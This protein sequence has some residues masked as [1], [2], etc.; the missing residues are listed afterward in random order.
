MT[1]LADLEQ[2]DKLR[3]IHMLGSGWHINA[4]KNMQHVSTI[5]DASDIPMMLKLQRAD[6]YIEQAEMFIFQAKKA[7]VFEEVVTFQQPSIRKLGWHI[8]IG[9]KSKFQFLMPKINKTLE[10]LQ[11]SGE[12]E[13]IKQQ[14]F[15]K[16]GIE[17]PA[18]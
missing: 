16:Y 9:H 8:F 5:T 15:S 18:S 4:L 1:S 3:H 13:K 7:G 6:V 14:I 11:A 17:T 2:L 12:L 10:E